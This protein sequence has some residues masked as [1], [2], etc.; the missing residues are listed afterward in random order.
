MPTTYQKMTVN[1][2]IDLHMRKEW[3][4]N[5]LDRVI[6][7]YTLNGNTIRVIDFK[8]G[9]VYGRGN[10]LLINVSQPNER[11]RTFKYASNAKVKAIELLRD[12]Q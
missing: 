12:M 9:C 4:G 11:V 1:G 8:S 6:Y 2:N 7:D 5:R 3:S 10:A